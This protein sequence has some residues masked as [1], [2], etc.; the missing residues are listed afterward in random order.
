VLTSTPR[1]IFASKDRGESWYPLMVGEQFKLR[2]CRHLAQKADDPSTL[3]VATGNGA[4][5][6]Q[7]A[8]QRST[9]GGNSWQMASLPDEP[10]SPIWAFATHTADPGLVLACSHYG[11]IYASHDAGERWGKVRREFSEIRGLAWV[12]N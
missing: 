5:G 2:Y 3:F 11:E 9:N 7:G 6:D 8:I 4:A 10:N 1:E 12:P